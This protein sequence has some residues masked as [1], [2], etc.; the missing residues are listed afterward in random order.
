MARLGLDTILFAP[1]V[2]ERPYPGEAAVSH[3]QRVALRKAQSA[4][5]AH[6]H[7]PALAA[8]TTV[9]LG[10]QIYGKPQDIDEARGMLQ[11]LRGRP[12]TVLTATAVRWGQQEACHLEA[13]R[14]FFNPF[15]DALLEWYLATGEAFDKAGAYAVQG[16]GALLVARVEG[17]VQAVVGLPLAPLPRLFAQVGLELVAAGDRL[18]LLPSDRSP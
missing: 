16:K 14:V 17:N 6:P 13:A 11:R 2:D 5:V 15:S 3:V 7:L 1:E 10:D 8:D 9:V 12:H 18:L 4:A